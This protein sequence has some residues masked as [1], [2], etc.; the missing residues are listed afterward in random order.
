[1]ADKGETFGF[2]RDLILRL[3]NERHGDVVRAIRSDNGSEFKNS[4]FEAFCHDLGLEHQFSFPY[5]A[6]QNGVVEMKNRSLCEMA[7]TMLEEHRTPRRYWAEAVNTACH[8]GNQIFLRAFMNKTCYELMHR[9]AP[10]VSHIRAFGCRCFI[11]KKGRLD[12][13]ESRSSD[14]IFMG[15]ASHSR[16]FCVLNL[17]TNLVMETCEVTFDETQPYNSIV[18]ECACDDEVGKKIFEDEEDDAGE[19]DGDDGEAPATRVPST[20]TTTTTVQDGPS[21]TPPMI[22]QDQVEAVAEGEVAS[23]REAPRHVQVDHPPS[24]VIG[25]INECTTRSRFRNVSHFAHSAF[26]ATFE[27][28]DIGHALSDPNWVN[29][30]HEELENFERNQAWELVE[31]PPNCKPIG[32]KWVWK[33]KDGENGEVVRNKSRL[34]AQG[35]SQK[36]GIDYEETF[37]P[38]AHLEAIR[39]LLAFSAAK[40]FKLYQMDVNSAFLNG[41]LE[42]DVYVK[43]PPAFESTEFPHKVYRLRKVL[44]GLKQASRAW[45]GR[46]RGFLFS[47]GFE[48]GKVDKT[49]YLLGQGD[50]ILI[51]Q[52]YV[53]DIV[54]GGLSHSLVAAR[55]AEDMSK[56]FEMSMMGEL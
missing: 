32:T 28:K 1:L 3:K 55:F 13:F 50:D 15:Y 18:F 23:R 6:C 40:G 20:P 5:V 37:A 44:Y 4:R 7:W 38:V 21:P 54:L 27:P 52:V 35:Y 11:I 49:L 42:E 25:D 34:V 56:E 31:P 9:R 8:V 30:M 47:K 45:Y 16:A 33:N 17:D 46:L 14:G 12:K 53:D 2:V 10:R 24:V 41:F 43:Q 36:E 39:I 19:D 51:F 29:A 22:Q 26:V 48:M